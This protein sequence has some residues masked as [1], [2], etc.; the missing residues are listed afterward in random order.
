MQNTNQIYSSQYGFRAGH[1]CEDTIGEVLGEIVKGLQNGKTTICILLDL[2]KAFDSLEHEMIFKKLERYGIRGTC[3]N[4]FKS[5]LSNR[6]LKVRCK[7][8]QGQDT[9]SDAYDV[10][11][12]TAQGSCLGPLIFMIFCNDLRLNLEYLRSIQFADDS[13]LL[14]SHR[15]M[16]YLTFC[17]E[18]DLTVIQDWFNAN[19]L[20]LNV[21]KTVCMVF[22]PKQ[23]EKAR[24]SIKLSETELPVVPCSKFLGLWIDNKLSWTEHIRGLTT[25]L[26]SRLGL[27]K[28]SKNLL[29]VHARRILYF[30]QVHSI[31]TYGMLIWVNMISQTQLNKLQKIQDTCV[32]QIDSRK[33]LTTVYKEQQILTIDKLVKLENSKVWYKYYHGLNP[34]RLQELMT[35]DSTQTKV[36]KKHDY[37]TR[38]KGELNLPRASGHYKN[39]FYVKG[40]KDYSNLPNSVKGSTSLKKFNNACKKYYLNA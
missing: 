16:R 4:W 31:L 12:G 9:Y 8:R 1:S 21:D 6:S 35:E 17:T 24:L 40:M 22:S 38:R 26:Y 39:S 23:S 11:Y 2:S 7:T 20:T 5:Y 32:S 27:L 18:H 30:A 19:K 29:T 15:N 37:N 10:E 36:T 28:R 14:N 34:T 25:R 3:L 33:A 13:T